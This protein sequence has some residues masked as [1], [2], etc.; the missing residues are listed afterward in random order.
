MEIFILIMKTIAAYFVIAFLSTN[1]LGLFIRGIIPSIQK[2]SIGN[3]V[4]VDIKSTRSILITILSLVIIITYILLL[5]KYFNHGIALAAIIM[6]ISRLPDLLAEMKTGDK[7]AYKKISKTPIG[8]ITTAMAWSI[9]PLIY[10][11]FCCIELNI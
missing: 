2:D 4:E 5:C 3:L 10:Y 6:M 11:S 9:L 8:I 1:L 7:K